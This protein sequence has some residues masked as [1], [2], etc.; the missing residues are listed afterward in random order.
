MSQGGGYGGYGGGYGPPPQ[1]PYGSPQGYG[2]P[3]Q[4]PPGWGPPPPGWGPPPPGW[5]PPQAPKGGPERFLKA[6]LIGGAIGGVASSLPILN[7][8]NC[9]FCL[10][11]MGGAAMAVGIHLKDNPAERLDNGDAALCGGFAGMMA[12][13]VVGVLGFLMQ[14]VMGSAL[15]AVYSSLASILPPDVI[16]KM[17]MQTGTSILY[18]PIYVLL[19]GAFG[20][21]GGFLSMHLFFK[22]R[23]AA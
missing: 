10:L 9:C 12:G 7:L 16:S 21:L 3:P 17:M 13:V 5:G 11:N 15:A 19:Y 20:A 8:L 4:Q 6:A 18:I 1:G 22:D 23:T 14:L 2:P